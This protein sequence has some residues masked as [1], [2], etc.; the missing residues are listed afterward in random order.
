MWASGG[1]ENELGIL[2]VQASRRLIHAT[3]VQSSFFKITSNY[4]QS[5]RTVMLFFLK[6]FF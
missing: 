3:V 2:K 5:I 4:S 1:S 6:F